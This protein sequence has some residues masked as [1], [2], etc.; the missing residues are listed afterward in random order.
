MV[1]SSHV[2]DV[3]FL[4]FSFL[5]RR[6]STYTPSCGILTLMH[7]FIRGRGNLNYIMSCASRL[8]DWGLWNTLN[9]G[10]KRGR[11]EDLDVS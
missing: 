7:T 11:K 10:K 4:S 8:F 9:K 6:K 2:S 3:F 1:S 5:I